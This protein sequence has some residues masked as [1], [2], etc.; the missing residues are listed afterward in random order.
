MKANDEGLELF[1]RRKKQLSFLKNTDI[2]HNTPAVQSRGCISICDIISKLERI[3]LPSLAMV[4]G[5]IKIDPTNFEKITL[6]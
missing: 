5:I 3:S 2:C 4:R 6:E 1:I